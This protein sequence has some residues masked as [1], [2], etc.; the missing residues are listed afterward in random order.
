LTGGNIISIDQRY[1]RLIFLISVVEARALAD[2]FRSLHCGHLIFSV[3][4]SPLCLSFWTATSSLKEAA[5]SSTG[6]KA[7]L[8]TG[9]E[10]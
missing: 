6:Q 2:R 7:R 4:S 9:L 5:L 8:R 10:A 3:R 1:K